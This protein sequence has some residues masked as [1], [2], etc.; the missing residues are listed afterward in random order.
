[1]LLAPG[2]ALQKGRYIIDALLETA[3]NGDLYWGTQVETGLPVYVQILPLAHPANALNV[4]ALI[5]HL[6]GVSFAEPFP[7]PKPFHLFSGE[8]HTLCLAIETTVGTP[9]LQTGSK[10]G[11]MAEAKAIQMIQSVAADILWLRERGLT[12]I[13]L[14]P[15]RVWVTAAGDRVT[16]TGLPQGYFAYAQD[17]Q[18]GIATST[19][20]ALA[21]LL[22]SFLTGEYPPIA[23]DG[24]AN[25]LYQGLQ[26]K[27]P[28]LHPAILKAIDVDAT[29]SIAF[30][31]E[32]AVQDWLAMLP[33][34]ANRSTPLATDS[35]ARSEG[36]HLA[37]GQSA[38]ER[39]R[40]GLY[41]TLGITGLVA[42]IA[43]AGLGTAWRLNMTALPGEIQLDPNQSFP[44]QADWSGDTPEAAFETPYVPR[45]SEGY[46]ARE[47]WIEVEPEVASPEAF[48]SPEA[49]WVPSASDDL[50]E[51][52][53]EEAQD[54][55][56]T[57]LEADRE[58][59]TPADFE[60]EPSERDRVIPQNFNEAETIKE[61]KVDK[62]FLD[63]SAFR[64]SPESASET[65]I[66]PSETNK[67]TPD[68]IVPP[69]SN[70]GLE[71][72]TEAAPAP[73]SE[74]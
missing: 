46:N 72:T 55:P 49:E 17:R 39:Q 32:D 23:T 6:Q 51:E 10:H 15:N 60:A 31:M 63:E 26:R 52:P 66:S 30:R 5:A 27:R 47:G 38:S 71:P 16:L 73:T 24:S 69:D 58:A 57:D 44:S 61:P 14:S 34:T 13:D 9:Y 7:L 48:E 35:Q 19:I 59:D 3:S 28:A 56:I 22:Y 42:A 29:A 65:P 1:M 33:D 12:H 2:T 64:E 4:S 37:D 21:V 43:G 25:G 45:G 41:P 62:V 18:T 74:S 20:Q 53:T 54:W 11:P 36:V 50:T 8:A 67:N 70:S 68:F 40:W